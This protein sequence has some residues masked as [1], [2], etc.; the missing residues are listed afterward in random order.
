VYVSIVVAECA[1]AAASILLFRR[2]R[3]K[4]QKI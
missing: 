1:I 3:W 4:G 2:G